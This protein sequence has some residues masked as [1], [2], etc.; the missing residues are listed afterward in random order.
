VVRAKVAVFVEIFRKTEEVKRQAVLL[1]DLQQREHEREMD[2][3]RS[4]LEADRIREEMRLA[5]EIQQTLFPVAPLTLPG[6]DVAGAS[7]P[8]EA[9]GGDYFD[10]IPTRDDGLGIVIGDVS[11]HGYGPALLMAQTRAYLRAFL[12][13]HTDVGEIMTLANRALTADTPDGRFT[14][15]LFAK[16]DPAA[17]TLCYH[18]AGHT[19][20]YLL[21]ATGEV[22]NRLTGTGL[23][24]GI[25]AEAR[26]E[27]P[28]QVA[29]AA[30]DT[31]V[32]LTDGVVEA[33]A[34]TGPAFG[35]VGALSVV[36]EHRARPAR[37]VVAELFTAV[38]AFRG[39]PAQVDDMTAVVVKVAS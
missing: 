30:G 32:L 22:K 38:N 36:R 15:L 29:L 24:L 31:L 16:L 19:T 12:L 6:Y 33:R 5:R 23:P 26:F 10:Y 8:A 14:T 7:H 27:D 25:D 37:E 1:R 21:D 2:A 17:Q 35:A 39:P 18:S 28:P 20:A 4:Q 11:G 13:T 9:T 3:V 34:A